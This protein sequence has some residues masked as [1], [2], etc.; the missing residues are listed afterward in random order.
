[1]RPIVCSLALASLVGCAS[2]DDTTTARSHDWRD[3]NGDGFVSHNEWLVAGGVEDRIRPA[4]PP[5]SAPR[6]TTDIKAARLMDRFADL[7]P[8]DPLTPDV[9]QSPPGARVARLE[10]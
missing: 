1:M 6:T 8:P 3:R 9:F 2:Y 10:F 7:G 4:D 5:R